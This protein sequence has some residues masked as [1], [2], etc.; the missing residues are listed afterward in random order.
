MPKKTENTQTKNTGEKRMAGKP[1]RVWQTIKLMGN[2][3]KAGSKI[4][5]D[6]QRGRTFNIKQERT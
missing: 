2:T 5:L 6:T 4:T 1:N 3:T